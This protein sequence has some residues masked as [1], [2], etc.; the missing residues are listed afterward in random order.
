MIQNLKDIVI[1]RNLAIIQGNSGD[2][3]Y[4]IKGNLLEIYL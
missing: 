2:E 1:L 3:G 4:M